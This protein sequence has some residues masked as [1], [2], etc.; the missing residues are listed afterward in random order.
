[1]EDQG[2]LPQGLKLGFIGVGKMATA[3]IKGV[4][5]S[6][7]KQMFVFLHRNLNW[8][9]TVYDIGMR[10]NPVWLGFYGKPSVQT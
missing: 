5:S 2:S 4:S 7:K 6:G 1:M 8:C 3:I 9:V 10:A